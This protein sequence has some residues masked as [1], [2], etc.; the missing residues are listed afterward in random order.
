[1][2]N[3]RRVRV[4]AT[5]KIAEAWRAEI[6]QAA[7][8]RGDVSSEARLVQPITELL[9]PPA[10]L[11]F[12]QAMRVSADWDWAD[13]EYRRTVPGGHIAYRPDTG[14]LEI[15]I[16]L[17][18]A[19]EAVGTATLVATGEVTDEVRAEASSRYYTD[20]YGG[21]TRSSATKKAQAAVDAKV[22]ELAEKRREA[23]KFQAEEAARHELNQRTDEAAAE[24]R[25]TAERQL[26]L[27]A[28]ELRSD[29]DQRASQQL[30]AV[31]SE[32]LKGIFQLVAAGYSSALQAYA[33]ENGENLEVSEEDGVIQIQFEV[34]G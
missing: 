25:S 18:V 31:Q 17:E 23:L 3:P 32:T 7:T 22:D 10:R 14:E 2:C 27:Q 33:A 15:V 16:R 26:T 11:A 21:R 19:I 12:E 28:A 9:P 20:G 1:M 13:G 4:Q 8:A 29:L 6:E 24:A 30:E 34:E 5:R